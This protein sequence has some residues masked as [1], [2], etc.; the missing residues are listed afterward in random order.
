MK[1]FDLNRAQ[2]VWIRT[3]DIQ[4]F[5]GNP[6]KSSNPRYAEIKAS[7][8][9]SGLQQ[10]LVITKRPGE[11][12]FVLH[13]GGNTRLRVL[14]ELWRETSD[15]RFSTVMCWYKPWQG[16]QST[17]LSHLVE[18]ELRAAM[19]FCERAEAIVKL[20]EA[21]QKEEGFEPLSLRALSE[22]L[23]QAGYPASVTM[24]SQVFEFY[25]SILPG[26]PI[27]ARQGLSRSEVIRLIALKS[28]MS[29]VWTEKGGDQ[30]GFAEV[31][32]TGLQ[33]NDVGIEDF[34]LQRVRVAVLEQICLFLGVNMEETEEE[35]G[36]T[37]SKI[38]ELSEVGGTLEK[39]LKDLCTNHGIAGLQFSKSG[40]SFS[41]DFNTAMLN[42]SKHSLPLV[43]MLKFLADPDELSL[44]EASELRDVLALL[45]GPSEKRLSA[46]DVKSLFQ[47]IT[48]FAKKSNESEA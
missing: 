5:S 14:K 29:N 30:S 17:L 2:S 34:I 15:E 12:K 35:E 1:N 8:L 18:N 16:E 36:T 10:P 9:E 13:S 37:K 45:V 38:S 26:I 22:R 41:T 25:S 7:V 48:T 11:T 20:C 33:L 28:E 44:T 47:I 39:L 46:T 32:M 6:R 21:Y 4:E 24:L 3:R 19:S 27:T 31:W 23:G 40:L 43:K 42:A